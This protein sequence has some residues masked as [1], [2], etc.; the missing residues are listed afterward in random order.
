MISIGQFMSWA[1]GALW[2]AVVAAAYATIAGY[3]TV[4]VPEVGRASKQLAEAFE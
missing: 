2:L 1:F 4:G 3:P